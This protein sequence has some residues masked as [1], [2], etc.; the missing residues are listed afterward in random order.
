METLMAIWIVSL[1]G[2]AV[3]GALAVASAFFAGG[4]R[5]M[6]PGGRRP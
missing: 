4:G 2:A 1:V 5:F 3:L 6:L